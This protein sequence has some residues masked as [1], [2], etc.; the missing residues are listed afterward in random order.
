MSLS[1]LVVTSRLSSSLLTCM[2]TWTVLIYPPLSDS[3]LL[4]TCTAEERKARSCGRSS[5]LLRR[6][7][8]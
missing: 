1:S 5:T 2:W 8:S 6:V 3:S 7:Q 4:R